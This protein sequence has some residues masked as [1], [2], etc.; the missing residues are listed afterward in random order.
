MFQLVH[1]RDTSD[2]C[3]IYADLY[4]KL[5]GIRTIEGTSF[6]ATFDHMGGMGY[7]AQYYGYMVTFSRNLQ[8]FENQTSGYQK[9]LNTRYI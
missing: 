1:T 7:D 2:T 4:S 3:Q 9:H 8:P 5:L 6:G